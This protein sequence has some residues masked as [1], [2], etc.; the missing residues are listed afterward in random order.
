MTIKF[1]SLSNDQRTYDN[2]NEG[3]TL[4][5]FFSLTGASY[6]DNMVRVNSI[7]VKEENIAGYQLRDGDEISLTP[8]K[9]A[10]ADQ[11]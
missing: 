9:V 5:A 11:A 3:L 2:L 7:Q 4:G 1:F 8:T 6:V 10:G